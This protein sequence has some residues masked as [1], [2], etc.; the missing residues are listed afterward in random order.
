MSLLVRNYTSRRRRTAPGVLE[1]W[2]FLFRKKREG[3]SSE[4]DHFYSKLPF[5][6]SSFYLFCNAVL[7]NGS[8]LLETTERQLQEEEPFF[9]NPLKKKNPWCSSVEPHLSRRRAPERSALLFLGFFKHKRQAF[10]EKEDTRKAFF[11]FHKPS[12]QEKLL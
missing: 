6:C 2:F 5:W 8:F 11:L 4:Q 7:L 1:E 3:S 10:F 12:I 9:K